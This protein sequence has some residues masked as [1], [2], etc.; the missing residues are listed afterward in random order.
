MWRRRDRGEAHLV[1][2]CEA[3]LNGVMAETL[4][5]LNGR[6]PAWTWM[7]LLAHATAADLE[8][9]RVSPSPTLGGLAG[10]WRRARSFLAGEVLDLVATGQT[11]LAALQ[12][13]VLVP[14]EL[15]LVSRHATARWRPGDLVTAVLAALPERSQRREHR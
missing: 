9:A 4:G 6:V 10:D 3:F 1:A 5:E 11:T 8:A 14:L 7:N 12:R 13:D 2:E 15:D